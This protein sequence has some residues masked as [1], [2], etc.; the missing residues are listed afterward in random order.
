MTQ[1]LPEIG[2]A[3]RE[4]H[5]QSAFDLGLGCL[6]RLLSRQLVCE[7]SEHL[8]TSSLPVDFITGIKVPDPDSFV[9][10]CRDDRCAMWVD[11]KGIDCSCVTNKHHLH[12]PVTVPDLNW[13]KNRKK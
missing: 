11:V 3:N 4:D 2:I 8:I 13:N 6:S 5:D 9:I 7:I 12:M 1:C 10:T